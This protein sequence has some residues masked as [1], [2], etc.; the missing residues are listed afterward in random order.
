MYA[1]LSCPTIHITPLAYVHRPLATYQPLTYILEQPIHLRNLSMSYPLYHVTT[2]N[3]F[4]PST[5]CCATPAE[6]LPPLPLTVPYCH[7]L[8]LY[9][10]LTSLPYLII[11]TIVSGI[12][13]CY[14]SST[15]LCLGLHNHVPRSDCR[16]PTFPLSR[17]CVFLFRSAMNYIIFS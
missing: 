10:H 4:V 1:L 6:L 12:P 14:V 17:L 15:P 2:T 16:T 5:S 11:F 3:Y 13:L 7:P 9:P 8:L